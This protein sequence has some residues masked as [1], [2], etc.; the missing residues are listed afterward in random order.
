MKKS[1]VFNIFAQFKTIVEKHFNLPILKLFSNNGEEFVKLKH[2]LATHDISHLTT[3]PHTPEING[4]AERRHRHIVETGRALLHHV[5]LPGQ[6]WSFVF[7]I[8]TYLINRMPTTIIYMKSP[9]EVLFDKPLDYN[10]VHA[11]GCLCFRC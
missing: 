4:T 8:A 6:F 5:K 10:R 2:F 1:D 3:P 11:F 9:Y 7:N